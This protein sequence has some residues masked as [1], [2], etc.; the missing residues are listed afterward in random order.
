MEE[1]SLPKRSRETI[2]RSRGPKKSDRHFQPD[3]WQPLIT[4]LSA[5]GL[6]RN[7]VARLQIGEILESTPEYD[8][9]AILVRQGKGGKERTVPVLPGHEQE[10]LQLKRGRQA[11]ERVFSHIPVHLDVHAYRRAFA[12]AYYLHLVPGRTLPPAT[13]RLRPTDY[14]RAA[15]EQVTRAL[16]HNRIDVVLRH[17]LR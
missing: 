2:T 12:Q 17:Y 14:D 11:Q 9:P 3:N 10:V 13:G 1:V 15:I 16:G 5:T 8:G 7:E 4:F 6:R